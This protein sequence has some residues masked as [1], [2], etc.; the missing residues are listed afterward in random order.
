VCN[1]LH[2]E[3]I[4]LKI[5]IINLINKE[6]TILLFRLFLFL[7]IS[8]NKYIYYHAIID[9]MLIKIGSKRK[10][11]I[12]II[13]YVVGPLMGTTDFSGSGR[14]RT[15]KFEVAGRTHH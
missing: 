4:V 13:E 8:V 14:V 1:A 15:W 2:I 3:D 7:K 11:L 6:I 12:N 9:D 5:I 10:L